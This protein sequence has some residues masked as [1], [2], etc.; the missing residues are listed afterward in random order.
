MEEAEG[1]LGGLEVDSDGL[2]WVESLLKVLRKGQG[3][4]DCGS[5]EL[6]NWRMLEQELAL[7]LLKMKQMQK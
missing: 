5:W 4:D 7:K 3:L 2:K 6:W 1:P